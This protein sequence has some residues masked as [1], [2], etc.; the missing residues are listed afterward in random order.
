MI[1]MKKIFEGEVD[2]VV[3]RKFER[4]S[5][6]EFEN[7]VLMKIS[8]GKVLKVKASYDLCDD[9]FGL[10][11]DNIKG[12]A[13]VFGK[14]I[15]SKD[16]SSE[17]SFD[18]EVKKG[19]KFTAEI[20]VELDGDGMKDLYE[21]FKLSFILLNVESDEFKLKVGK[22]LPKPGSALKD[23]FCKAEFPV[24]LVNEFV[25]EKDFKKA[26]VKHKIFVDEVVAPEGVSDSLEMRKMAKRKGKIVRDV[27]GVVSE[28][29]FF[30]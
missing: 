3:H 5:P 23:N 25:W 13:R 19:K 27:D 17:L 11:A 7:R 24:G 22:S 21:K 28:K 29:E 9:F 18:A 16:F 12:K 8:K 26:V 10:I 15:A 30:V 20:D 1:F 14:I 4:F 6:G 2:E